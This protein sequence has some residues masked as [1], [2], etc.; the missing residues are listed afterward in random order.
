MS[1]FHM[2]VLTALH[3]KSMTPIVS[4]SQKIIL[5]SLLG[6]DHWLERRVLKAKLGLLTNEY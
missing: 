5:L 6:L 2:H 1:L 4:C 3:D